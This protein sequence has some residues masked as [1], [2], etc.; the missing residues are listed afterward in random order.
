MV[1][2]LTCTCKNKEDPIKTERARVLTT[3]SPILALWEL[4]V[5]MEIRVSNRCGPNLMQPFPHPYDA[6]LHINFD[7]NR[8][9]GYRDFYV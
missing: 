1:V 8:P 3:C 4:S 7:C 9:T 2:L 5:A 6:R